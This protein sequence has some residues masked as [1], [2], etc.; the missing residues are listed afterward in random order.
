MTPRL[1]ALAATAAIGLAAPALAAP[2][3]LVTGDTRIE[4]TPFDPVATYFEDGSGGA[5]LFFADLAYA[6]DETFEEYYVDLAVNYGLDDP[7]GTIE[8]ALS[9]YAEDDATS[10]LLFGGGL[11]AFGTDGEIVQFAFDDADGTTGGLPASVLVELIFDAGLPAD[12]PLSGLSDGQ[13]YAVTGSIENIA[14]IPLPATLPLVG[15][16]LLALVGLGRR[17]RAVR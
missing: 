9:V 16:G 12:D 15:G 17:R 13:T 11:S 10:E 4:I 5:D 14:P 1:T 2:L 6:F 3:D 7:A 8:G